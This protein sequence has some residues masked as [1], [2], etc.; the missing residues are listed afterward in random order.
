MLVQHSRRR[1]DGGD[2]RAVHEDLLVDFLREGAWEC[3][4]GYLL[5]QEVADRC[6]VHGEAVGPVEERVVGQE[7]AVGAF[8]CAWGT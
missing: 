4:R 1:N 7:V 8:A 3:L 6:M 2:V 5:A